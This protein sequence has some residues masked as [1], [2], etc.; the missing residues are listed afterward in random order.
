MISANRAARSH[1]EPA[2]SGREEGLI[3]TRSRGVRRS[4]SPPPLQ[5]PGPT[6]LHHL[7]QT[8][9]CPR[10]GSRVGCRVGARRGRAFERGPPPRPRRETTPH[11]SD[12]FAVARR[13]VAEPG[14]LA[15]DAMGVSMNPLVGRE[16]CTRQLARL[17]VARLAS[18]GNPSGRRR[19]FER[20]LAEA[21]AA[22]DAAPR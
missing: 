5:A 20:R 14:R 18:V 13:R 11:E 21:R 8:G 2:L 3:R 12:T 15:S 17:R 7:A 1:R 10:C 4:R 19:G 6:R 22:T 16:E 9:A